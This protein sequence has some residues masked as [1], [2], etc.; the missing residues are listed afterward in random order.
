MV[1][2]SAAGPTKKKRGRKLKNAANDDA[3]LVGGRTKS[4]ASGTSG[5][6]KRRPSEIS[7]DE[8]EE[9]GEEMAIE[10]V[11]RTQEERAREVE[12]RALLVR[13][14]DPEQMSRYEA[15]RSGRLGESVVRRVRAV[16]RPLLGISYSH[17]YRLSIRR[18]LSQRQQV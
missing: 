15:Y 16:L 11:A 1:S 12:H 17:I 18:F 4:T 5:R 9:G 3:S 2:G 8:E 7:A 6:R 13:Q 10:T 14:L